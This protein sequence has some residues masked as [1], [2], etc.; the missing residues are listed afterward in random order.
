MN[1]VDTMPENEGNLSQTTNTDTS[2]QHHVH[3]VMRSMSEAA[4]ATSQ[5]VMEKKSVLIGHT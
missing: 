5:I 3:S 2:R 1:M 4:L